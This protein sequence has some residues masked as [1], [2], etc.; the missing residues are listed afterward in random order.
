[1]KL[2]HLIGCLNTTLHILVILEL[3][4]NQDPGIMQ[5]IPHH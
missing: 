4:C 1:M 2:L 3:G 5:I